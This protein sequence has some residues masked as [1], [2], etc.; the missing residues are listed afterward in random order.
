MALVPIGNKVAVARIKPANATASGIIVEGHESESPRGK[1]I[2]TGPDVADV[3][4]GDYVYID[5]SKAQPSKFGAVPFFIIEEQHIL[6]T[7]EDV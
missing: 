5:W 4:I 1:V 6:A 2:A 3:K 7:Y